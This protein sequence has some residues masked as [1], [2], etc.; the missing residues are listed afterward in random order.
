MRRLRGIGG[1]KNVTLSP[2]RRRFR[3]EPNQRDDE[4]R[5]NQDEKPEKKKLRAHRFPYGFWSDG[6]GA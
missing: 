6:R 3:F 4:R 1:T 5:R 2:Q